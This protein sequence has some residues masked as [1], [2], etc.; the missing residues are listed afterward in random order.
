MTAR[1]GARWSAAAAIVCLLGV[2]ATPEASPA[3]AATHELHVRFVDRSRTIRLPDGRRV[4]RS[5]D[6]T[7]L[8]PVAAGRYPLL[9]FAHGFA[10]A[11]A[12]YDR[13]LRAWARAGYV[14]AAPTFPLERPDAPGGP[15]RADLGN[16][17]KD[18]SFVVTRLLAWAARTTGVLAGEIDPARIGVAGHSDGGIAALAVAYDRRHRDRRI[19]AATVLSGAMPVGMGSFPRGGAPLLA[20]HGTADEINPPA[21]TASYFRLARRPK[22]LLWLLGATHRRP[23]EDEQPQLGVVERATTA[24]FDHY[25]S[26][27]PLGAFERAA[28]RQ[29]VT[30]LV[31][32]P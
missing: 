20:V 30:R 14:V 18:M 27:G 26:G 25:L 9:V 28:R 32:D 16:E 21:A 5:L 19:K 29:G 22:F 15:T 7:V 1:V 13:L 11:P 8:Y 3:P 23:F 10:V 24:F 2:G 17:P 6:T 31:A 4:A 12:G